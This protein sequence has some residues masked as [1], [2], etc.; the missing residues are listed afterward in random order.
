MSFTTEDVLLPRIAGFEPEF[1][2]LKGDM[3]TL[4]GNDFKFGSQVLTAAHEQTR[5][6]ERPQ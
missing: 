2:P 1:I 4:T 6:H 3:V 5:T